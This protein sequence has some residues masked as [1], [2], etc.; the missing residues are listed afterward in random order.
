MKQKIVK[1]KTA[2]WFNKMCPSNH[3]LPKYI[4]FTVSENLYL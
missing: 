2:I 4:G 3:T 1:T